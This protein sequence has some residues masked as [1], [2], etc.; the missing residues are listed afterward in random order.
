MTYREYLD[1]ADTELKNAGIEDHK[2]C[3]RIMVCEASGLSMAALIL[4]EHEQVSEAYEKRF[5]E[6]LSR[7]LRREP[8]EYIIGKTSFM[9]LD[10]LCSKDCLVP[11]FDTE[12]LAEL[13]V[14]E[15]EKAIKR[16]REKGARVPGI[17]DLCTGT[18]CVGISVAALSGVR[19]VTLSDISKKAIE[20]ARRNAKANDVDAELIVS[21][22]FD[23]IEGKFDIITANPPYIARDKIGALE[24]E[25]SE[26]EPRLA[27][28]GGEDGLVFYRRIMKCAPQHM[29]EGA[30]L[31]LET[32]DEQ[33]EDVSAMMEA[34]GLR[35]VAVHKDLAGLPRVVCGYMIQDNRRDFRELCADT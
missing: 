17:L 3:A 26:F 28:D 11:R 31:A 20:L 16:C 14:A 8:L 4:H 27:L 1:K 6:I 9:G 2:S 10:I 21:D 18:G 30:F 24:P 32:G 13:A 29:A 22:L 19:K 35:G 23:S 5:E 15:T 7:R 12:I 33:T 34:A 25:V